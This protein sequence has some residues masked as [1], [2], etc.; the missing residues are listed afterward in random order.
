MSLA[1]RI[2]EY[3]KRLLSQKEAVEIQRNEL[4]EFFQCVPSQINY[5]LST[6][7]TP[8]ARLSCGK[9]KGRRRLC[10]YC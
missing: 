4:A 5:V 1:R 10:T 6:R 9:Q 8:Y 2:E 3:L 7:F